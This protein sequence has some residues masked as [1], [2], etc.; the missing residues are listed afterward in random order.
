MRFLQ[1]FSHF[2]PPP[3]KCEGRCS[4]QVGTGRALELIHAGCF[5]LSEFGGGASAGGEK[6]EHGEVHVPTPSSGCSSVTTR[7]RPVTGTEA[8]ARR[9]GSHFGHQGRL[10][11]QEGY[12]ERALQLAQGQWCQ[13]F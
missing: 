11:R 12:G 10:G 13:Q 6:E 3:K 8:P 1:G 7:A 5:W 2:S 4:L 9:S